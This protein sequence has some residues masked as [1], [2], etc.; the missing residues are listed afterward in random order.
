MIIQGVNVANVMT[1]LMNEVASTQEYTNWS[2][3]F[4]RKE[5]GECYVKVQEEMKKINFNQLNEEELKF[6]GFRKFSKD[7]T[8]YLIPLWLLRCLPEG[9][10]VVSFMGKEK[11]VGVDYIDND[12]RGGLT[13]YSLVQNTN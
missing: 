3:S 13:A 2:D 11:T 12:V 10:K 5:I 1:Y 7:S 9:T 8:N 6:L 4:A